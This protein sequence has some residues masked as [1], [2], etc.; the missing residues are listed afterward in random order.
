MGYEVHITRKNNWFDDNGPEITIEEWNDYVA[1]DPEM[2]LDKFAETTLPNEDVLRTEDP[3]IAVWT[4]YSGN[5]EKVNMAWF[6]HFKNYIS[7]KNPDEEI[8][9]KMHAIASALG[10]KVQGDDGEVYDSVGQSNWQELN[11]NHE[12]THDIRKKPWWKLWK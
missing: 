6:C 8:L 1:S 9:I 2:R 12:S 3:G 11:S 4:A 7:V 10:A 5:K